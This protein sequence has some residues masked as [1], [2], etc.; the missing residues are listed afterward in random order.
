LQYEQG[1][2]RKHDR[3]EEKIIIKLYLFKT[4]II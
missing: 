3:K 4:V 1:F 2:F